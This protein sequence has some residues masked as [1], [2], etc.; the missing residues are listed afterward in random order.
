[1]QMKVFYSLH[2]LPDRPNQRNKILGWSS[3][4]P[5]ANKWSLIECSTEPSGVVGY[6][7]LNI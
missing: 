3:V 1:M 4:W 2:G 5:T 7:D 6:F